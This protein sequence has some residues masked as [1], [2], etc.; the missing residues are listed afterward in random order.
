L[1][2]NCF[3]FMLSLLSKTIPPQKRGLS[4]V[5]LVESAPLKRF[6]TA[7]AEAAA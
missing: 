1:A 6:L 7:V 5:K 4:R 2:K 3:N